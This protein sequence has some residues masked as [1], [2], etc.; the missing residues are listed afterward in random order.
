MT[1][2]YPQREV[3]GKPQPAK[4]ENTLQAIQEVEYTPANENVVTKGEGTKE[5]EY[6]EA[7]SGLKEVE[8]SRSQT[9][10]ERASGLGVHLG[11]TAGQVQ[12]YVKQKQMERKAKQDASPPKA[13][14]FVVGS[15]GMHPNNPE[16]GAIHAPTFSMSPVNNNFGQDYKNPLSGNGSF[17]LNTPKF[18]FGMGGHQKGSGHSVSPPSFGGMGNIPSFHSQGKKGKA[19]GGFGFG[20]G[21]SFFNQSKGKSKGGSIGFGGAFGSFGKKSKSA[22]GKV[23]GDFNAFGSMYRSAV[24]GKRRKR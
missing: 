22:L 14:K 13:V 10:Y 1:E 20:N 12:S 19:T 18:A 2:P 21:P 16:P 6:Q 8:Y 3:E 4:K 5:K 11:Q 7:S 17:G 23:G 9:L 24:K 15:G